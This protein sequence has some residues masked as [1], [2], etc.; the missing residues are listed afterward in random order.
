[1]SD[2][3]FQNALQGAYFGNDK[4]IIS[5][6]L[7]VA[8]HGTTNGRR[9]VLVWDKLCHPRL[10]KQPEAGVGGVLA[11]NGIGSGPC[12]E[13]F[14]GVTGDTQGKAVHVTPWEGILQRLFDETVADGLVV[15]VRLHF[16]YIGSFIEKSFKL[17]RVDRV[18]DSF[19]CVGL[20]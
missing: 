17:C 20:G 19:F 16:E 10:G 11:E 2:V 1:M 18:V 12:H 3:Y 6:R 14:I 15:L 5:S 7:E 8:N 13:F 4:N 9:V